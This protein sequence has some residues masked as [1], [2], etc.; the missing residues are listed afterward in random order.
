MRVKRFFAKDV[1]KAIRKVR[2][3]L[4]ADA[5]IL[6]NCEV[7][8]G[9]EIIAAV[10]Y[11]ENLLDE[12]GQTLRPKP[13][14]EKPAQETVDDEG[15]A[16]ETTS[17]DPGPPT[18][19]PAEAEP[20]H[21]APQ[22]EWSQ[23]PTLVE[24][25]REL[26]TLRGLVEHQLPGFAW[27]DLARRQPLRAQLLRRFMDLGLSSS[28]CRE[29]ASQAAGHEEFELVWRRALGILARRVP[30]GETDVLA[31]GGAIA[32]VGPTGV[33]KTT[34]AAKLAARF[35]LANGRRHVALVTTDSFRIG[36]HEQLRTYGRILGIPVRVAGD[37]D[38]LREILVELQSK[39]FVVIDT[40]GMSQRD[41]RLS[42]QFSVIKTGSPRIKTVLVLSATTQMYGLDEAVRAFGRAN[43]SGCIVTKADEAT[44]LGAVLSVVIQHSLPVMFVG[45]GQRVPEDIRPARAHNLVSRAVA[46]MNRT[47]VSIEEELLALSI[48]QEKSNARV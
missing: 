42:E 16:D 40:A 18:D 24:M 47:D 38:E 36:A 33:G 44:S 29:I 7:K 12:L 45:D 35:V 21:R 22:V 39:R 5:V 6:S 14:P 8:G 26:Q 13:E 31:R 11:D 41:V 46:L 37:G 19:K 2:D 34:T 9:I 17:K 23:E 32:L 15:E 3:E 27:G 28:L 10:E 4:G 48:G 20:A 43:P 1:R 30:I 25:R